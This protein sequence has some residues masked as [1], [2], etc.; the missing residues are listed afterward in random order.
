[1]KNLIR[2]FPL[3]VI[4]IAFLTACDHGAPENHSKQSS[5]N[6]KKSPSDC[7]SCHNGNDED[8][9]EFGTTAKETAK[10]AVDTQKTKDAERTVRTYNPVLFRTNSAKIMA[11]SLPELNSLADLFGKKEKG[12]TV[13]INGY[14]DSTG[15]DAYNQKLSE[16]RAHTVKMYLASKGV[17]TATICDH[18][19]GKTHPV[20]DNGTLLGR[21]LNRRA[22]IRSVS[23]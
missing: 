15:T 13:V 23:N 6:H 20:A 11:M 3:T 19:F 17:D 12:Y 5:S 18:G 2:L 7:G 9:F 8:Y 21:A 14:T 16:T 22:E 10:T 1:M 4:V